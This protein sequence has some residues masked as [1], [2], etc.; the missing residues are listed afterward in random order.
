[1]PDP[2]NPNS[3][4]PNKLAF[5]MKQMKGRSNAY[6]AAYTLFK[7]HAQDVRRGDAAG[8]PSSPSRVVKNDS[9][10]PKVAA[11]GVID[12]TGNPNTAGARAVGTAVV[13]TPIAVAAAVI[14][15]KKLAGYK[16]AKAAKSDS[17]VPKPKAAR[18]ST[19]RVRAPE[20]A[21]KNTDYSIKAS[22][23]ADAN[24][25]GP[26]NNPRRA[27]TPQETSDANAKNPEYRAKVQQAKLAKA[28]LS[29]DSAGATRTTNARA[30]SAPKGSS[31]S[32]TT[33]PNTDIMATDPANAGNV[34]SSGWGRNWMNRIGSALGSDTPSKTR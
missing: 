31:G 1:M 22:A 19:S 32:K 6:N 23:K 4:D 9:S 34:E 27:S 5:Y 7:R 17:S 33:E 14:A 3:N 24:S 8:H 10:K 29:N 13:G 30:A 15:R 20:S 21:A 26:A 16:A 25:R 18:T 11:S 28:K 12:T 2:V